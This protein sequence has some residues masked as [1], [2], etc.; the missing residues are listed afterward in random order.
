MTLSNKA[1]DALKWL[2]LIIL[3]A[4]ATA[5]SQL[6]G[7]WGL[8]FAE[9]IPQTVTALDAF[10]G[11]ALGVSAISYNALNRGEIDDDISQ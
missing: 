4:L 9:Q 2:C 6:A 11:A 3:P 5:Y 1:Y 8:P 10:L 7:I